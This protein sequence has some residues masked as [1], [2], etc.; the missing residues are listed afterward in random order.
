[1]PKNI[2]LIKKK[3]LAT[4]YILSIYILGLEDLPATITVLA[5]NV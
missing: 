2:T 1:M 4:I 3:I 5:T